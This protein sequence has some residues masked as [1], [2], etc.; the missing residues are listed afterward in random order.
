MP[1]YSFENT[2][3][4]QEW[5]EIMTIAE[6]EKY[7]RKHKDVKQ[8]ITAVNIVSGIAGMTYKND[9][10]WKE[11]MSRIAEAHP[12]SNLAKRYGKRSTKDIQTREVLDKHAVR[13]RTGLKV[14]TPK[15]KRHQAY[16][17]RASAEKVLYMNRNRKSADGRGAKDGG[18]PKNKW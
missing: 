8:I 7:L 5:T 15:T 18:L 2:K 16:Q 3:T 10:G 14:S 12:T 13:Q 17:T 1:T 6:K 11:N 9:Q 4:G